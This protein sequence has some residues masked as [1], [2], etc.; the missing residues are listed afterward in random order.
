MDK[1]Q[2]IN[3]IHQ[4]LDQDASCE[5]IIRDLVAQ[6]H[7][8]EAAVTKFVSQTESEYRKNKRPSLPSPAAPQ[9]V[10]LP[11]WLEEMS[12]G[13]QPGSAPAPYSWEAEAQSYVLSQL[14][15]ERLHSD[16]ADELADRYGIPM[17][18]AQNFVNSVA[19]QT[20]IVP[21]KKITNKEEAAEFVLAAYAK[22]R[23][24]IEIAA[25]LTTRTGEPRDLTEKFVT[26]TI[27]KTEQ[28]KIQ[29][30]PPVSSTKPGVDFNDPALTRF[31]I[32]ELTKN[33]KRSDVVMAIC[34]RTG[35]DWNE[36]QRFVGQVSTEQHSTINARKN[37]MIIPMCIG[38]IVIGFAFTILTS[39]PM[40][41]L[42]NGRWEEFYAKV[43]SVG[44][45]SDYINA[46]PYIFGTG[47]VLIAGG[48]I[49]LY[50][51]MQSQS[52]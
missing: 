50:M 6:I 5:E 33:R 51:A 37:R 34:E 26:L 14:Q 39:Y 41:Y 52:E 44:N 32:S 45:L 15:F 27:S 2:A 7:A 23:S 21:L 13:T 40:I 12:G 25:E 43:R 24:K 17:D 38:A 19:A 28:F 47:V 30:N 11:A 49:G 1:Q 9:P 22:G 3:Y 31:V 42:V 46:A 36:A 35:A 16:I 20:Y 10:K 18:R 8:P 4:R 48:I 29:E